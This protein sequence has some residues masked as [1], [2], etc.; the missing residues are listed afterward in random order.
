[1]NIEGLDI[2]DRLLPGLL[3]R[4]AP[5]LDELGPREREMFL[6]VRQWIV[7]YVLN[8]Q[9]G[10]VKTNALITELATHDFSQRDAELVLSVLLESGAVAQAD[11]RT[12]FNRWPSLHNDVAFQVLAVAHVILRYVTN[13]GGSSVGGIKFHF[14]DAYLAAGCDEVDVERDVNAALELLINSYSIIREDGGVRLAN[15][16][17]W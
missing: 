6:H 17:P 13:N 4:P 15:T 10:S 2:P 3:G 9:G 16:D 7:V 1:M 14:V 8:R 11:D 5:S 12:T